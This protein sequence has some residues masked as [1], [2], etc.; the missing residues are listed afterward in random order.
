VAAQVTLDRAA[1]VA[2]AITYDLNRAQALARLAEVR[3]KAG[4]AAQGL[5]ARAV[6]MARALPDDRQHAQVLQRIVTAQASAGLHPPGKPALRALSRA[7]KGYAI[8]GVFGGHRRGLPR[9]PLS[10]AAFGARELCCL[11]GS[12]VLAQGLEPMHI[13]PGQ[14]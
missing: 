8:R 13:I 10:Q 6:S 4:G 1:T 12:H 11:A 5:F 9:H 2:E 3:T 7:G 14:L